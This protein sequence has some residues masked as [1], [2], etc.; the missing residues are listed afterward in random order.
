M[1][2]DPWLAERLGRRVITL[3]DGDDPDVA[4]AGF[5]QTRV[6]T[7]DVARVA[8]LERAGWSVVDVTV[9]LSR[10]PGIEGSDTKWSIGSPAAAD[11]EALLAIAR[12]DFDV[13]RFHL[14]PRF[15][16]AVARRIKQDWLVA[17]LDGE[18][19]DRVLV[20]T[21]DGSATG[22]LAV[23]RTPAAQVIDLIAVRTGARGHGAGRAL[24]AHLLA[25]SAERVEVGTQ[26]ANVAALRFYEEL[27]FRACETRYVLHCHR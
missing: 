4:E 20:A 23:M 1:R 26:I 3:D 15:P 16:D 6:A 7:T 9:T 13:S 5:L 2:E 25:E 17:C 21:G 24:V 10:D 11:R 18:R 14:D 19:G 8:A 27:G 22:F 12:D